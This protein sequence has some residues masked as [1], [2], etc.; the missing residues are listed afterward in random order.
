MPIADSVAKSSLSQVT[1]GT[2]AKSANALIP[3]GNFDGNLMLPVCLPGSGQ[4][5]QTTDFFG[6]F[7]DIAESREQAGAQ[8]GGFFKCCRRRHG[9]SSAERYRSAAS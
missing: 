3:K 8:I 9:A 1:A 5:M 2:L 7:L 4:N 6:V